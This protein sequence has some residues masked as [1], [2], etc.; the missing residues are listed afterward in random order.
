[1]TLMGSAYCIGAGVILPSQGHKCNSS[2]R[3]SVLIALSDLSWIFLRKARPLLFA[4]LFTFGFGAAL[5]VRL[6][7]IPLVS[8]IQSG[9]GAAMISFFCMLMELDY[10]L[11]F[12]SGLFSKTYLTILV[13]GTAICLMSYRPVI[14]RCIQKA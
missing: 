5:P 4:V 12:I 3:A 13:I 6:L 9:F 7:P 1:M 8:I 2:G 14:F 10:G 11:S